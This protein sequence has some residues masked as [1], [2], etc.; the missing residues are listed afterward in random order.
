RRSPPAASARGSSRAGTRAT[1]T[2]K[3]QP[4]SPLEHRA[5][6]RPAQL[7]FDRASNTG[8][9]QQ[10]PR[11]FAGVVVEQQATAV[12]VDDPVADREPEAGPLIAALRG[13]E[14][15]EDAGDHRLRHA[16]AVI[17]DLDADPGRVVTGERLGADL[18][19]LVLVVARPAG[20]E[21]VAG[22][23]HEVHDHLLDLL[24]TAGDP[25]QIVGDLD[26]EQD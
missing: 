10:K 21:G 7:L 12:V 24:A 2:T 15:I 4:A 23:G 6:P 17:A 9:L 25:G 13:E 5:Q 16:A 20:V 19:G 11:S 3:D 26:V 18:D 1:A 14:G 22:V 8:Q